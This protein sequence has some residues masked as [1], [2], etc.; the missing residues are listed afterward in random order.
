MSTRSSGPD[1]LTQCACF[2]CRKSFKRDVSD[3]RHI[4]KC[5]ECG[6]ATNVMGRYFRA[7]SSRSIDQWRKVEM[8]F[9]AGVRFSG[10]QA[11]ALG[12]FPDT[13]REAKEFIARNAI[14][15]VT[16]GQRRSYYISRAIAEKERAEAADKELRA[17]HKARRLAARKFATSTLQEKESQFTA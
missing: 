13:I 17:K 14:Q 4:P 5:P 9:N 12:R 6:A 11:F 3:L 10:T 15:L 8:L 1:Y 7:P 2:V 16:D